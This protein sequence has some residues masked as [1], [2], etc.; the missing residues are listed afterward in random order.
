LRPPRHPALDAARGFAVVAMVLG[1]TLHALLS[2]EARADVWVQR[3]WEL[4]G[5][6]AP[7]FLLVSG[8]ALVAALDQR[9]GAARATY[10]RRLQRAL[11]LIFLGYLLHWPGWDTVKWLGWGDALV[12]RLFEFDALQCI[13]ISLLVG[14]TVL[15]LAPGNK[16]RALVLAVLAVGIPLASGAMWR[17]APSLPIVLRQAV[18]AEGSHFPL[19]PWAGFFFAGALAAQLFRLLRPGWPQGLAL[20]VLGAAVIGVTHC[21]PEDWS[22]MSPWL[23]AFR[24]GE[25]LLVLA[26]V[27]LL[28]VRLSRRLAP[29]GRLSLWVYVLHLPVVYG[30]AGTLGLA[31]RVGP[32]LELG[33]ALLIGLGLLVISYTVARLGRWLRRLTRPWRPTAP[34]L[35]ISFRDSQRV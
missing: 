16:S 3:Y 10:G 30:W 35:S 19:F 27:S 4:R 29:V 15:A 2:P 14:A 13:G 1:H 8:W 28:P 6:T 26:A 9:P 31:D 18:G 32:T 23:V 21:V 33:P 20:A 12:S 17:W 7:L 25:G 24:V 34:A 5:I 11:L 22:P